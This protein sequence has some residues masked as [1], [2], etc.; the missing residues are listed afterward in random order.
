MSYRCRDTSDASRPISKRTF[1]GIPVLTPADSTNASMP[2]RPNASYQQGLLCAIAAFTCW[3]LFPIYW[4]LLSHVPSVEVVCHRIVW[5]FVFL[6][7]VAGFNHYRTSPLAQTHLLTPKLSRFKLAR[8]YTLA[9]ILISVNW[10]V[11]IWAVNHN[12]ILEAS[13]GYY[14][15]PL[16]SVLLGVVCLGEKLNR[17]QGVAIGVAAGGVTAMAISGGGMPWISLALAGSFALYGMVKKA[18]P[19][20]AMLGLLIETTAL[21]LPAAGYL[22]WL[23]FGHQDLPRPS[24]AATTLLLVLGGCI[25]IMPLAFFATAAQRVPLSTLGILQYFAPT[26]QFL[27][28]ALLYGEPLNAGK[29]IG[30]IFVWIGSI[31]F[32]YA[33]R[34]RS[35]KPAVQIDNTEPAIA[36]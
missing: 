3:G 33:A 6:M 25:T 24:D 32:L 4:R 8:I 12:R 22:I 36:S 35:I 19:L 9:A 10:L 27:V 29:L 13:L 5:S 20:P 34:R 1:S 30:F 2:N 23:K 18:A 26:L 31:A 11:F 7:A 16:L 17:L 14:I 21:L 28:G 15:N